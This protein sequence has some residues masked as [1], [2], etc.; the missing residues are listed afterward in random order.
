M[1]A[2]AESATRGQADPAQRRSRA[3]LGWETIFPSHRALPG[4][5]DL[6][7]AD[8]HPIGIWLYEDGIR[9]ILREHKNVKKEILI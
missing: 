1:G 2:S 7:G 5:A 3:L 8:S 6:Q 9:F 4:L